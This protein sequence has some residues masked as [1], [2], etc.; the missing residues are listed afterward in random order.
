MDF[1]QNSTLTPLILWYNKGMQA[2]SVSSVTRYIKAL[3]DADTELQDIWIEGEVSNFTRATSGHCYFTLKD[4]ESEIRCVMWRGQA[5]RLTWV[6]EQ[7]DL[8]EAHGHVSVYERGGSYQFYVDTLNRGGIGTRWQEFLQ[9]KA[10]LEAEG[11]F[12]EDRKRPLPKWPHRIGVVTSP[13]GAALRD[14]LHVLQMRYPP[15]EVVLS[16]S[17]VQGVDA[18]RSLVEAIKRLDRLTD[19]DVMIIARGGGSIEDLWAFND[20]GVARALAAT[21]MPVVSGVGHETDFTIADF[22]ADKRTPTPSAAAA[23]VVP[24]GQELLAQVFDIQE[25]LIGLVT[26]RIAHWRESLQREERT[27]RLYDPLRIIAEQRQ[28]VDELVQRAYENLEHQLD[29]RHTQVSGY[30]ARLEAL[31]PRLVIG[32]GYAIVEDQLTG[33]RIQSVEQSAP[34]KEVMIHVSDGHLDAE[35]TGISKTSHFG[36]RRAGFEYGQEKDRNA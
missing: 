16:P 13:T 27:L 33:T 32:R 23:A 10:R 29:M 20:E 26:G 25:A 15:V 9:L 7:G 31:S 19:I 1:T 35:I 4:S 24:D 11:L 30:K 36:K 14:I 3:I 12:D 2:I 18:P 8:V 5:S 22:V 17:L 21:R 28:R 6:P 34:G